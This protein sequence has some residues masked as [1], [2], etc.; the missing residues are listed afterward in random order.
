MDDYLQK[1]K[2]ISDNL[3]AALSPISDS[4]LV[5][6][7]L[8]GLPKDYDSICNSI[9]ARGVPIDVEELTTLLLTMEAKIT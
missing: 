8:F 9:Y 7:I 5:S 1:M 2:S 3:G 4:E 6:H